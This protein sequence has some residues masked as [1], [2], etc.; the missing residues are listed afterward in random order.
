MVASV[1]TI[2]LV[3]IAFAIVAAIGQVVVEV[4]AEILSG[5]FTFLVIMVGAGVIA[6]LLMVFFG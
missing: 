6:A 5:C 1:G 4:L 2:I 3:A